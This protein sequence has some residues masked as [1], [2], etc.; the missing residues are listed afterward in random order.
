MS[1][2]VSKTLSVPHLC[3]VAT[4]LVVASPSKLAEYSTLLLVSPCDL[5]ADHKDKHRQEDG[6]VTV[7][8]CIRQ[9]T[10]YSVQAMMFT[11]PGQHS[12]GFIIEKHH[13][14]TRID[15]SVYKPALLQD[16]D[17]TVEKTYHLAPY[18]GPFGAYLMSQ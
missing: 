11:S 18:L 3:P 2:I 12:A 15:G 7:S 14:N 13:N 9:S 17:Y 4:I 10:L 8:K 5:P 6:V 1:S 16:T